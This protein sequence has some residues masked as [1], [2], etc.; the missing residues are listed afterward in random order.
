MTYNEQMMRIVKDYK[1]VDEVWPASI[2]EMAD[3]AIRRGLWKP[4]PATII[5]QCAADIGRA[6]REE[7]HTDRQGREVRT[8]HAARMD[9]DGEQMMLW[10]DIRTAD[11]DHMEAAFS[12]RRKHIVGECRSLS[13]D[14]DSFNENNNKGQPIQF[15]FDFTIDLIEQGLA[16]Q[17]TSGPVF[18]PMPSV[19]VPTPDS[20]ALPVGRPRVGARA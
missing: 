2:R 20:P 5:S 18:S 11:R 4:R 9:R 12:L 8:N 3:W 1:Q 19:P 17:R 15:R 10:A 14:V 16:D 7:R 6:M 13:V